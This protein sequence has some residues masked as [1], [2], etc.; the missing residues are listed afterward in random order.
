MKNTLIVTLTLVF[1]GVFCTTV[2]AQEPFEYR[3]NVYGGIVKGSSGDHFV[4]LSEPVQLPD[5]TLRAGTYIFKV[6]EPSLVR[7]TSTDRSTVY[8]TFFTAPV[9]R[10][11]EVNDEN[12]YAVTLLRRA[13]GVPL[14]TKMFLGAGS[15]G[16]EP[17]YSEQ[18]RGE[19]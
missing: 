8:A 7:V 15:L 6:L 14:V 18:T 10:S 12:S 3:V 13:G 11:I 16:F 17:I 1:L 4:T 19:R 2:S 9:T 5:S